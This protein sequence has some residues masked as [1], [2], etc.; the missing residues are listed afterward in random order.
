MPSSGGLTDQEVYAALNSG[1]IDESLIDR[2]IETLLR[3]IEKTKLQAQKDLDFDGE[4][5]HQ[6]AIEFAAN[7]MVLLKNDQG[8]LPLDPDKTVAIIGDFADHPRYQGSGSSLIKTTRITSFLS[9]A[10][11]S[12]M[13]IT[14]YE[15][16]FKRLGGESKTLIDRAVRLA[17]KSDIVLLFLGLDEGAEAEGVDRRDMKLRSNQLHLLTE[18]RK[19]HDK[20][21]LVLS[22]GSPIEMP[23]V[24]DIP[25][26]LHSYLSGQGSGQATLDVLVGKV[27]PSGKLAET[28][29][30]RLEDCLSQPYCPGSETTAEHRESIYV[31]YRYLEKADKAV[32]FPF[33]FGLSYTTFEYSGLSVWGNEVRFNVKNTGKRSGSEI[34]QLYIASLNSTVFKPVK[35]LKGFEKVFLHP[36]EKKEVRIT[37]DEHAFAYYNVSKD[38]WVTEKGKYRILIGASSFDIRLSTE[39]EQ[40]DAF[41]G[42]PYDSTLITDYEHPESCISDQAFQAVLKTAIPE[43]KWDRSVALTL[44]DTL[45]QMQYQNWLGTSIYKLLLFISRLL[46]A[47]KKPVSSN[48]VFFFINM[49]IRSLSRFTAGKIKTKTLE[50]FL[51]LIR[52]RSQKQATKR[53]KQK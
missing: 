28:Y 50:R 36:N 40:G 53:K 22:G 11:Q 51:R 5:H 4:K 30:I 3:L 12:S 10:K 8:D 20:I 48:N 29:P 18:L 32:R 43:S 17:K 34:T 14:G 27:N 24:K 31:G 41:Y 35:E 19:V 15:K 21:V 7:S 2:R 45:A 9:A 16:G 38:K 23:F 47:M 1:A 46:R 33:G 44:N 26:I 37:L 52:K 49:P 42:N 13:R 39:V 25:A 6:K